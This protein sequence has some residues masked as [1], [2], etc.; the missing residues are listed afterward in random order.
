MR[1]ALI[2]LIVLMVPFI[3]HAEPERDMPRLGV[4][5]VS[6]AGDWNDH[7]RAIFRRAKFTIA[8]VQ[9]PKGFQTEPRHVQDL[10]R[11]GAEVIILRGEDCRPDYAQTKQD[12]IGRG[13][14]DVVKKNPDVQF[15]V[16][17]GNEPE[18][19]HMPVKDYRDAATYTIERMKR[20]VGRSN[21]KWMISMPI[22]PSALDT[23]FATNMDRL[24]DGYGT[25]LYG[26]STIIQ[27]QNDWRTILN[28]LMTK[29]TKPI[30]ITEMGINDPNMAR[31]EKAKRYLETLNWLDS[32][33]V[34]GVTLWTI[35]QDGRFLNYQLNT[36]MADVLAQAAPTDGMF[37]KET[38]KTV[39]EPFL[40]FFRRN[41][42]DLG[43][44]GNSLRESILLFGYPITNE[45]VNP[46]TG[47]VTQIFERAVLEHHPNNRGTEYEV[48]MLHLGREYLAS[49]Q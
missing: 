31:T 11:D 13:F 39:R 4:N 16:E 33:R 1:Y 29:H 34:K 26:H 22:T 9:I 42:L 21:L 41:G 7:H 10:I 19:C 46:K 14:Y 36:A 48:L 12:L 6:A 23:L 3:A 38:G 20:E 5:Y 15:W 27:E 30:F 43:D 35:S 24:V 28:R 18:Y 32:E 37:F 25:H 2:L 49:L 17:I 47:L 44:S 45:F 8:K 40:G